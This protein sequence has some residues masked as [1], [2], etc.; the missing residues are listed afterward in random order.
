RVTLCA[1]SIGRQQLPYGFPLPHG[2]GSLRPT[3]RIAQGSSHQGDGTI[4]PFID[5]SW[6]QHPDKKNGRPPGCRAP[7][8]PHAPCPVLLFAMPLIRK[9]AGPGRRPTPDSARFGG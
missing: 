8:V 6:H 4:I 7:A 2:H 1:S 9:K 3:F 5:G